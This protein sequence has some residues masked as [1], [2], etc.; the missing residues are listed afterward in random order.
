MKNMLTD[1][2]SEISADSILLFIDTLHAQYD[3]LR[4]LIKKESGPVRKQNAVDALAS[5]MSFTQAYASDRL[6]KAA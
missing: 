4:A 3:T 5:L 1:Y 6:P 2:S